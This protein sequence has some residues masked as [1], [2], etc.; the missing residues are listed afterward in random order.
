MAESADIYS[1]IYTNPYFDVE[2]VVDDNE[3]EDLDEDMEDELG[4]L[5]DIEWD[6]QAE[7]PSSI[8][9]Q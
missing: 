9:S 2:A 4:K 3:E 5:K 1:N 8:V 7:P 6:I